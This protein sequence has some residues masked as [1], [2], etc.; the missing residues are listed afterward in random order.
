MIAPSIP[1]ILLALLPDP[2]VDG[3]FDRALDLLLVDQGD[4]HVRND[5]VTDSFRLGV[6][7]DLLE[8]PLR[9]PS[10]VESLCL[11]LSE[12]EG[13]EG[14][15]VKA[16]SVLD[17][18]LPV[19]EPIPF[20]E[21]VEGI[22]EAIGYAENLLREAFS[23]LTETEI[24][25]LRMCD[26]L[27]RADERA[28]LMSLE[29]LDSLSAEGDTLFKRMR[30]A[31]G[32]VRRDLVLQATVLLARAVDAYLLEGAPLPRSVPDGITLLDGEA[33]DY[34]GEPPR[35]LLDAG[36]DDSYRFTANENLFA[37]SVHIDLGGDDSYLM[38]S[39]RGLGCGYFGLGVHVD[40]SGDDVYRARSFALGAGFFGAGILW[41]RDGHDLYTGDIFCQGSGAFGL[42]LL[43]DER[44]NDSYT[45]RFQ[46]QGFGFT[47]GL[48][49]ILEG[50]GNDA[51]LA[52]GKYKDILRYEDHYLSLSQG[53]GNGFRPFG[54][55]GIGLIS[56]G[57]GNDTYTCDI[58]GQAASY[59]FSLGGILD[60]GGNDVYVAY[61]YAQ[62]NGTHLSLGALVEKDGDDRYSAKG[63][64]Q[65]CG[66]DLAMGF[67][68]DE[69]GDDQ[70]M[71][72][73]L[74]MGAGNANGFG[75]LLDVRGDDA[76]VIHRLDNS[77][78]YGNRRRNASSLGLCLDF[79][80]RDD[81]SEGDR[82]DTFSRKSDF[83]LRLD[84]PG[85]EEE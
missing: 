7:T 45:S 49:A 59:W 3:R 2:A 12:P 73:D 46:S 69:D 8:E 64:S 9:T 72:Y 71:A 35:L 15:I 5:H 14:R 1:L 48:G 36:G 74:C 29:E 40:L 79:G 39:D 32:R 65:G 17:V 78:G 4:V 43:I 37:V 13:L 66:H 10:V 50:E 21:G 16:A 81:H 24:E 28:E 27:L 75:V 80:G 61:Q 68:W 11:D 83:G 26:S 63:V 52:D 19:L 31:F 38:E 20:S 18:I 70:Y 33:N 85:G 23:G 56:E 77:K 30:P 51:Y 34:K 42:G 84:L 53:F 76:Y 47:W 54:S 57:G 6:V 62:G 41:D 44:G 55:G 22:L 58:F 67:L 60:R 82:N 25:S